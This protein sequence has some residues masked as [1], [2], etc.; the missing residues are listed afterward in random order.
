MIHDIDLV[1][2]AVGEFPET[3]EGIGVKFVTSSTDLAKARLRFPSGCIA[4]L[5]ASRISDKAERKMRIFQSGLY[6]SLDYASGKA[7]KLKIDSSEI[8]NPEK[9]NPEEFKLEKGDALMDE[10]Q[11]FLSAIQKKTP[12]LVSAEDGLNAMKVAWQIKDQ[13]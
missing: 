13:L 2:A 7:R 6:L 8:P 12:T 1:L 11:S 5:T 10:I 9:L 4:D 3:V